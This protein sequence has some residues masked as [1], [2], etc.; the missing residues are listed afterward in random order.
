MCSFLKS[1][2]PIAVGET[3]KGV[4]KK[5]EERI[6][7]FTL[8]DPDKDVL[9]YLDTGGVGDVDIYLGSSREINPEINSSFL[10]FSNDRGD[11]LLLLPH[12]HPRFRRRCSSS[13]V[14]A[15]G[16]CVFY[17]LLTAAAAAAA[18]ANPFAL[19]LSLQTLKPSFLALNHPVAQTLSPRVP[20]TFLFADINPDYDYRLT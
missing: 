1:A 19:T 18:A 20:A 3:A 6:F 15:Q 14:E 7:V 2:I 8:T 10:F 11:D 5:D 4:L 9:L 17:V 13:I 12:S 16:S